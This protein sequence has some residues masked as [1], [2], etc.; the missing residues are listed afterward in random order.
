MKAYVLKNYIPIGAPATRK[1]CTGNEPDLR[2]SLG[3]T[4][5]WYHERLDID[6]SE[7]WHLDPEYRYETL[8]KMKTYLSEKFH[9][10]PEFKLNFTDG[11]ETTC[12]TISGVHGIMLVPMIYGIKAVYSKNGWPDAQP[13]HHLSKGDIKKLKPFDLMSNPVVVQLFEQMDTIERKWG[14]IDGY[15]NYQGILNIALKVRGSDIFIDM[16]DD[17]EFAHHFFR[18]IAQT[19]G[20]L[21][22]LV[23]ER[24]RRSGFYVN[25]LSMSNCVV[26]MIS[27]ETYRE[28]I[29]PYDMMLSE[30]YER[31]GIHTCNWNIT[32][33]IDVLRSIKKMGYIDMGIMS[34]MGKVKK[35]FPDARRAV[36]YSPVVLEEKSIEDIR[37][38]VEKIYNELAPCDIVMA[39]VNNT[40]P[41][42][43][44]IEFLNVAEEVE[45]SGRIS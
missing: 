45:K 24:Q 18:H 21:S 28:F 23:Q 29:L 8:L 41:D 43:R 15:L 30:E 34:D 37:K 9:M 11:V 17:P 33:Y 2:V 22:K 12:A 20:D 44:I 1:P 42:S 13:G 6:F 27:P 4:P 36:L 35:V 39:D 26:N 32:P 3:F 7:R 38:D 31:F 19:I 10:V 40:T 5:K 14:R 25:L 16:L